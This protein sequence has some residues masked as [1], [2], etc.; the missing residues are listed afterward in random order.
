MRWPIFILILAPLAVLWRCVFLGEVIGPWA[1][2]RTFAPW[3]EA[4]PNRP[5]DVLQMDACLQFYV[6]RDLVFESWGKGQIPLWNPYSFG[7]APLLANSQSGALYPLHILMGVLHVPTGMAVTLLAWFHLTW[8]GLGLF[9]LCRRL[10]GTDWGACLAGISFSLSA[11]MVSWTGLASVITTVAWI[12]WCLWAVVG[13]WSEE[14]WR[15]SAAL[16]ATCFAMMVLGGHLQFAAFGFMAI[17]AFGLGSAWEWRASWRRI[18]AG[19]GGLMLGALVASPHLIPVLQYS[20]LSHRRAPATMAGWEAYQASGLR[21]WE[22]ASIGSGDLLG[23]PGSFGPATIGPVSTFW[24]TF[25]KQGANYAESAIAVGAV[26]LAL[27]AMSLFSRTRGSISLGLVALL[28]LAI[29]TASPLAQGLYFGFPGWSATGS[30]GRASV[31]VVLSLCA[32]AG[33]FVHTPRQVKLAQQPLGK[34]LLFGF[35]V[36][37]AGAIGLRLLASRLPNWAQIPDPLFAELVRSGVGQFG[38]LTVIVLTLCL[39][40]YSASKRPRDFPSLTFGAGVLALLPGLLA[41]SIRTGHV[42][43]RPEVAPGKKI[44]MLN[45]D[46]QLFMLPKAVMPPNLA[47]LYRIAEPGGYDSL[48][49]RAEVERL[50][51][52]NEGRDPAPA[53][54]GNMMFVKSPLNLTTADADEVWSLQPIADWEPQ[55]IDQGNGTFRY[56]ITKPGAS[57]PD[58]KVPENPPFLWAGIGLLGVI[59]LLTITPRRHQASA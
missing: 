30:P 8:A 59:A 41:C 32:L 14:H 33:A 22:L 20:Q 38:G 17:A 4:A 50:R 34:G 7:G 26:I 57:V 52:L 55:L 15:R 45:S 49:D 13:L 58:K 36:A 6:W 3:S 11:F 31:M 23:S 43:P 1:E 42:P 29:A 25:V 28:G 10:G 19:L 53:A 9:F 12:P 27:A 37:G 21:W 24:P 44:A 54:N 56:R 47:A 2:V 51:Q 35:I 39:I 16:L 40:A 5:Y 46:W 18:L 48:I